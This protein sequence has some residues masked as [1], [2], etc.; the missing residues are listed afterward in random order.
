VD[1]CS[2]P[3]G[4][5]CDS[6][7]TTSNPGAIA[8]TCVDGRGSGPGFKCNC[9]TGY[10]WEP[11]TRCCK[12]TNACA[13]ANPCEAVPNNNGTCFDVVAPGTGFTCRCKGGYVW[14]NGTCQGVSTK[15][16]DKLRALNCHTLKSRRVDGSGMRSSCS[17]LSSAASSLPSSHGVLLMR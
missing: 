14:Q 1:G 16:C 17:L 4:N 9:P 11:V 10:S 2:P 6:C 8:A 12:D 5:P 3:T 15:W 13:D 7:S